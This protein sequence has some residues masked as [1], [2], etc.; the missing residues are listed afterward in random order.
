MSEENKTSA[1]ATPE[2]SMAT[3]PTGAP[4]NAPEQERTVQE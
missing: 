2:P 1:P 3:A 4:A